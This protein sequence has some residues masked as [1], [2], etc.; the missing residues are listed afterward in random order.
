MPTAGFLGTRADALIDFALVVFIAAPFVMTYALRLAARQD[1][2]EH[3]NLQA[4]LIAVAIVAIL[5]LEL[6][7]RYG[8]GA[9][10]FEQS[11]YYG[12]PL[13]EGLFLLHLAVAIPTFVGWCTL[14]GM[15]WRRF[16]R[17][18]PGNFSLA[19]RRWGRLTYAGLWITCLTGV[20]L[21]VLSF[22]L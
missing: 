8:A 16:P 5:L 2:R 15:S 20:V 12:T 13:M 3:R 4:G 7:I 21:Y 19:H 14:V 22:A 9:A 17:I 6:S 1:F 18:L 11:A 10:A